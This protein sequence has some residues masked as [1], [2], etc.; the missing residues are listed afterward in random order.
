MAG[1]CGAFKY[2]SGSIEGG[3]VSGTLTTYSPR[4]IKNEP[5]YFVLWRQSRLIQI[6]EIQISIG[7]RLTDVEIDAS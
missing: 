3:E 5:H 7:D 4:Y 1:E 6:G 2:S